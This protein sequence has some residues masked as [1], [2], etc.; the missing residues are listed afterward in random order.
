M[1]L[2]NVLDRWRIIT[3]PTPG[4]AIPC[5]TV[6]EEMWAR[7]FTPRWVAVWRARRTIKAVYPHSHPR[8]TL[9]TATRIKTDWMRY[10]QWTVVFNAGCK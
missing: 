4:P 1:R 7:W 9:K 5:V 10:H 8:M 6:A 2:V 3:H